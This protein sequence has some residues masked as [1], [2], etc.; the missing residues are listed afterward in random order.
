MSKILRIDTKE[1]TYIFEEPGE[2]LVSLG[3]RG[4][5][6]KLILDEVPATCHPLSKFN[7]LVIAPGLLSGTAADNS[8][9]LSIGAKSPLTGGIKENNTGGLVSQKLARLGIKAIVLENK[10]EN[11]SHSLI[12]IKKDSVEM[13]PAN[14]YEGFGNY[15]VVKKLWR[16][17]GKRVGVMSIGPAGEQCLTSASIQ[18]AD[19]NRPPGRAAGRGGLNAVMGSKGVKAIVVDDKG[20]DRVPIADP[21]A[22]KTANKRWVEMLKNHP[23]TGQGLPG[24]GTAILVNLIN[25]AGALPTKNFR[26]GCFK[27][28]QDIS[29]ERMVDLIKERGGV[30]KE[31]CHPGCI[32][33]CSQAYHDK[34]GN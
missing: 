13:V 29:G 12:V 3:G 2:D 26:S 19:P 24:L 9:R 20:A 28:A 30:V 18:F 33:H 17:Y 5:T 7:K 8:G 34:D 32:I 15:E 16:K 27:H 31:G 23:V 11:E 10:P 22:F 4:L 1:K 14:E 25:E 6:S 21:E